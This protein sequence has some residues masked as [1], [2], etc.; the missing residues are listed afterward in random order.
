MK[1]SGKSE[2]YLIHSLIFYHRLSYAGSLGGWS[3]SKRDRRKA[4][5]SGAVHHKANIQLSTICTHIHTYSQ[6][7]VHKKMISPVESSS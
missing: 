5:Y 2:M 7:K 4:G 1:N 3:L 6:F